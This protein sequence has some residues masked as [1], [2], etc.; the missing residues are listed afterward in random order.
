MTIEKTKTKM[1]TQTHVHTA[2]QT[3]KKINKPFMNN[4]CLT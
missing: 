3:E 4:N 2:T 1:Y